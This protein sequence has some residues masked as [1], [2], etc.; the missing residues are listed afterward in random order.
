MQKSNLKIG[1][2]TQKKSSISVGNPAKGNL[3]VNLKD[4]AC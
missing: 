1:A 3:K 4:G 2:Q